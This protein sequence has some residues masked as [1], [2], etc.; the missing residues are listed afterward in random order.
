MVMCVSGSVMKCRVIPSPIPEAPPRE[1]NERA[2]LTLQFK[3]LLTSDD[4]IL[5]C[6]VSIFADV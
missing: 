4:D 5:G 3:L 2:F 1:M 6:H